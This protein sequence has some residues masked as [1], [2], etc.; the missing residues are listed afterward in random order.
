MQIPKI[1]LNSFKTIRI[2]TL[3]LNMRVLLMNAEVNL[4][5]VV[6]TLANR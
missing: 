4:V 6:G 3:N 5:L 2:M 1:S